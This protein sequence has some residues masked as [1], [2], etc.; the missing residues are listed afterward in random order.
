[1]MDFDVI[2]PNVS[3]QSGTIRIGINLI[4]DDNILHGREAA[5]P[6][7]VGTNMIRFCHSFTAGVPMNAVRR[8]PSE[9]GENHETK[10]S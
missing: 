4:S 1:M 9:S 5:D 7:I 2:Q 8:F 10:R 3:E 6:Q